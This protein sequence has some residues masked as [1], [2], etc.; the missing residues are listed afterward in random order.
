MDPFNSNKMIA[1]YTV[2]EARKVSCAGYTFKIMV[3]W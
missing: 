1:S 3:A 2:I